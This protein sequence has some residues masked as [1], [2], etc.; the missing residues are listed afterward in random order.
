MHS[1]MR[2][3]LGGSVFAAALAA[4]GAFGLFWLGVAL[5][6][7]LLPE[8]GTAWSWAIPG[9]LYLILALAA[10]AAVYR[11]EAGRPR[12][13]EP[14]SGSGSPFAL[15]AGQLG[16]EL[17]QE[18]EREVRHH[19]LRAVSLAMLGGAVLGASPELRRGLA[20]LFS[21]RGGRE[22]GR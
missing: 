16:L 4:V 20:G 7:A 1:M 17:G 15:D 3:F 10:A 12:R 13:P 6:W 9:M 5:H 22:T 11:R 8:V 19:P 2:K 14:E 18:L 21:P